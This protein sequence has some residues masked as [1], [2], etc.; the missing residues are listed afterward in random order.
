MCRAIISGGVVSSLM[1]WRVPRGVAVL[2]DRRQWSTTGRSL[3]DGFGGMR[4]RK[5]GIQIERPVVR[6]LTVG[7]LK[8]WDWAHLC[9]LFLV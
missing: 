8:A 2:S 7:A 1:R 3:K 4:V 6:V 5:W 9:R